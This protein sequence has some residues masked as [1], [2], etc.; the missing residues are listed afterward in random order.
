[1]KKTLSF[2]LG[3]LLCA[4]WADA[5]N[6]Q[7]AQ[8]QGGRQRMRQQGPI[9]VDQLGAHD[10]TMIKQGDTYYLFMTGNG[11]SVY[12][13]K[14]LKMWTPEPPVLSPAPQW[15]LDEVPGY[16]GHTW[17][18][19]VSFYNGKYYVYYSCS[20]FGKNSSAIGVAT[21]VT[22]DSSDPAFKWED[23]GKVIESIPGRDNWNA[24]DPNLVVDADG[25]AWLLFGSFWG[26]MKMVK[27]D[28]TRTRIAQPQVWNTVARQPRTTG[29][30]E[31]EAGDGAIEAPFMMVHDGWYYLFV[32]LDYC[33][34][35]N[36]S[37]YKVAVGRSRNV[38][39]PFVDKEGKRMVDGGGT[40]LLKGDGEKWAAVGHSA[41]YRFDGKD[42]TICHGYDKTQNGRSLL[43]IREMTW[44]DDG[45][46]VCR[47]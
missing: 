29:I 31:K 21:N 23:Q 26:G 10:P 42:Y 18:P 12:S 34:R 40:I 2:L 28:E 33:C 32:S 3:L 9:S 4:A 6:A 43:I 37:T 41:H 16:R 39:G 47:L 38:Q 13:S 20:S 15:A 36:D 7:P 5:Q 24:I 25:T 46:P 1:M 45:W 27:L 11:V 30:G 19:D 44:D 17:A 22:L 8:G 14:D 35:G